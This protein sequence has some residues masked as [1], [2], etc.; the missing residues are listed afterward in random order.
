MKDYLERIGDVFLV[1]ARLKEI[2]PGY[3]IYFNKLLRRFEVHNTFNK[4]DT[5]SL[6]VPF[7]E[8]DARL[9]PLV[10]KTRVERADEFLKEMEE[11]NARIVAKQEERER[12]IAKLK[13]KEK[14]ESLKRKL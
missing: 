5:L 10:R 2:D 7:P 11:E 6:V 4:G 12:E 14:L 8:I 13:T 1:E 3:V 9:I